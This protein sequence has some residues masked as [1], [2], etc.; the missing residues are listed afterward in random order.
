MCNYRVRPPHRFPESLAIC[1]GPLQWPALS[2]LRHDQAGS[3]FQPPPTPLV[4]HPGL[5]WGHW[6]ISWCPGW[7]R[8][9]TQTCNVNLWSVT[10]G[11]WVFGPPMYPHWMS[12]AT[13]THT[14]SCRLAS[15]LLDIRSDVNLDTQA[16]LARSSGITLNRRAPSTRR[17]TL[18]P[19]LA[20]RRCDYCP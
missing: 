18:G 5:P 14:A 9:S 10:F 8:L 6:A 1:P 13:V 15:G 3:H 16:G 17:T 2:S 7:L 11:S 12:Q 20:R 19:P 4:S